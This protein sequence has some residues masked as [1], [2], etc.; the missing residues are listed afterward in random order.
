MGHD[1]IHGPG[2]EVFNISRVG[3][4]QEVFKISR[5]GAGSD[6][7][8]RPDPTRLTS[9]DPTRGNQTS[10]VRSTGDRSVRRSLKNASI[11]DQNMSSIEFTPHGYF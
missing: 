2:Q 1:S 10:V 11:I 7:V 9:F 5:V 3:S 6:L 4:D 8:T